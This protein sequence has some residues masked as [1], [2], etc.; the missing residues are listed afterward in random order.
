MEMSLEIP[1]DSD[2]NKFQ[3]AGNINQEDLLVASWLMT[4]IR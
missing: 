4:R 1:D 3:L 2:W